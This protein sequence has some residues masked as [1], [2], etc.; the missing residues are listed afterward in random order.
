MINER[1]LQQII[2]KY[3]L[4][5]TRERKKQ[6]LKNS[7]PIEIENI[8]N[9]LINELKI[10][11]KN[12]EKCPSILYQRLKDIKSNYELLRGKELYNY[13]IESCLHI[14]ETNHQELND[15]YDYVIKYYGQEALNKNTTILKIP[16]S[17]IMEVEKHL[18]GYIDEQVLLGACITSR[19]IEEMVEILKICRKEKVTVNSTMFKQIPEEVEK[20]IKIC[21]IY[22]I[23]ITGSLFHKNS[24]SLKEI[25]NYCV[26]NNISL[27]RSLFSCKRKELDNII[28][29][30]KK[31][32]IDFGGIVSIS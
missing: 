22:N 17:K 19:T 32:N 23:E 8:L 13:S 30:C 11:K 7:D 21:K 9:Y 5:L 10:D 2:N 16:V 1:Q 28:A 18:K 4:N 15:T 3:Q 12:I 27:E 25:I 20:I 24:D 31:E 29:T 14:L 26:S 6:I